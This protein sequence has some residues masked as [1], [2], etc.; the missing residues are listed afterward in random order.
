VLEIPA[1]RPLVRL[2]L[3]LSNPLP[4]RESAHDPHHEVGRESEGALAGAVTLAGAAERAGFD[5]LWV[6]DSIPAEQ[7]VQSGKAGT[8]TEGAKTDQNGLRYEAYSL[9]GAL[10]VHTRS[11]SL[12]ALPQHLDAR[13][14]SVL[15]KIVTTIDVLSHGRSIVTLGIGPSSD[16][17][18][19]QRLAE[20]IRVCRAV[21]NDVDP[22]FV[23]SFYEIHAA[24]NRPSPVRSGG[25]PVAVFVGGEGP[26]WTAAVEVAARWADAVVVD[27]DEATVDRAVRVVRRVAHTG[28]RSLPAV[29]VIWTGPLSSDRQQSSLE[30]PKD[31]IDAVR[32]VE[33]R[34]DAGAD[35][36]IVSIDGVDQLEMI[37]EA[38][39]VLLDALGRARP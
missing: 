28:N 8:P 33:A 26:S 23:G 17:V 31:L 27:G 6:S 20:A 35:G 25:I 18:D 4:G 13:A 9:L 1:V 36:C 32:Q 11:L 34:V 39:P 15:A 38:G 2:G 19:V 12:G 10:A 29:P 3:L 21:L 5:S 16:T 24:A 37:H 30:R 7:S 22:E 14:P